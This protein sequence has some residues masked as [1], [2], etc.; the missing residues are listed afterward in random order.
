MAA[1]LT[2]AIEKESDL[3]LA[4]MNKVGP[5]LT[6]G[7]QI[8]RDEKVLSARSVQHYLAATDRHLYLSIGAPEHRIPK[9]PRLDVAKRGPI[10]MWIA[11]KKASKDD[12][13]FS[14]VLQH[15][16]LIKPFVL[17]RITRRSPELARIVEQVQVESVDG[18][19]IVTFAPKLLEL[20]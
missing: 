13:L 3:L 11:I 19:Y 4:T 17:Q 8:L 10:E 12:D 1:Q 16:K 9:L 2:G 15:W 18:W 7:E 5:L 14:P 20:P 6:Q